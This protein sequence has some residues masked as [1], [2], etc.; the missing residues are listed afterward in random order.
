MKI[1]GMTNKNMLATP[2]VGRHIQEGEL[3]RSFASE[4]PTEVTLDDDR[5]LITLY[6]AS[7]SREF[8]DDDIRSEAMIVANQYPHPPDAVLKLVCGCSIGF[9]GRI[10]FALHWTNGL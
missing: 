10:Q 7:S 2:L 3:L 4:I 6:T 9:P 1:E 5:I 8:S